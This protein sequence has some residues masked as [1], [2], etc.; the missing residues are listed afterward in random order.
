MV[1]TRHLYYEDPYRTEFDATV[2]Q[3]LDF[4]GRPAAVLDATAFYPTSGGQPHD[5]GS[6]NGVPL[7]DVVE[8]GEAIVHVLA[9]PLP[10][11]PVHGV[12]DWGRRLDH[13]QQHTGQHILSQA[14]EREL[15]ADTVSFHLGAESST[16][17]VALGT[18][19]WE[20]ASRVEE[21]ANRV[22]LENR[23]ITVR[24]YSEAEVPAL[25]L[26]RAPAVHGPIRVVMVEGFDVCACGGTHL[27]ATGEVGSVHIRRWERRH[28]QIRVEFLCGWRALRDYRAENAVCLGLAGH[29]SVGVQ[30]LPEAVTRLAEAEQAARQQVQELRKRLLECELPRLAGQAR[31][32]DT[33]NVLCCVLEGYDAAN[34]RYAAQS[35]TREPRWVALLAVTDPSP[36]L[37]FAR[38]E[39][40]DLD[41]GRLF[42]EAVAPYGGRGGG[43]P[44]MAQG[45][46]VPPDRLA[47]VLRDALARLEGLI[48]GAQ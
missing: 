23:P 46:G 13:M 28:G 47:D 27:R 9:A 32:L 29:L 4:S 41:M 19:D 14:F 5:G 37:C 34:M 18:L 1:S 17:D 8:Q 40:L 38:S 15:Q 35:L 6:L 42:Q 24:E 33:V 45:G 22:V 11:G 12:V 21:L 44:H 7:L 26:R 43:R 10:P 16:I 30:E 31:T 20:L 36:Q 2:V 25:P 3:A 39:D 48:R